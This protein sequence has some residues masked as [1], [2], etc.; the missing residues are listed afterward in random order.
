[1]QVLAD[2][3]WCNWMANRAS[4]DIKDVLIGW[5]TLKKR[6][7][8][9]YSWKYQDPNWLFCALEQRWTILSQQQ[10]FCFWHGILAPNY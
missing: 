3:A 1:M 9:V 2:R 10:Q 8:P 7:Q 6:L 4:S 5:W